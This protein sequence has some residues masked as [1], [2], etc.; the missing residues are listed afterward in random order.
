M[1]L[2]YIKLPNE[3]LEINLTANEL[4]VL[5]YLSSIYSG[6]D[7]V[8]VKQSTIAQKCG[9]KTT[10]TVSRITTSLSEK[11]LIEQR[12]CIYENNSTG[13]IF[14]TLNSSASNS[15]GYFTVD[16][17]ILSEG[18][19]PIQL[20]VYLHICR[21]LLPASGKCWNSYNDLA[22]ITGICRSKIIVIISQLIAH[23][24]IRKQRIKT[25]ENRRVYGDNHYTLVRYAAHRPIRRKPHKKIGLPRQSS[26][27]FQSVL[28]SVSKNTFSAYNNITSVAHCQVLQCGKQPIIFL[29]RG[30]PQNRRSI[31]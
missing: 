12:R 19:T 3:I 26:P 11:G 22:K 23:N 13:M 28:L 30:S 15:G 4:A 29:Q 2:S 17:H 1:K 5:F 7:T 8:R 20:K 16:R 21:A 25:R 9:L 31:Y 14:Y 10:Q 18:L 6:K 27:V 24:V